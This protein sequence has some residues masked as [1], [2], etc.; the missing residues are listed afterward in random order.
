[1]MLSLHKQTT[2]LSSLDNV[3]WYTQM[4]W[5]VYASCM[6]KGSWRRHVMIP[7]HLILLRLSV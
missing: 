5:R 7:H 4:Q 6:R 2:L 3:L 1:M